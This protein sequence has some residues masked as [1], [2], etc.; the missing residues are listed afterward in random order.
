M[1]LKHKTTGDFYCR[2]QALIDTGEYEEIDSLPSQ[3][4]EETAAPEAP[5]K[6][7]RVPKGK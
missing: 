4:E 1:Y 2:T 6:K 5:A 3:Q 7:P